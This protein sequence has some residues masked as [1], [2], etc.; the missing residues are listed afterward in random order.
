MIILIGKSQAKKKERGKKER[1]KKSGT[2]VHAYL[3]IWEDKKKKKNQLFKVI[4]NYELSPLGL[5]DSLA[6]KTKCKI[7]NTK[8]LSHA[9]RCLTITTCK[10]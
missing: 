6:Q 9:S 7:K 5:P 8:R 4:L 2:V 10:N 1:K 3:S